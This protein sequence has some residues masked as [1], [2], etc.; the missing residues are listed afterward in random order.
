MSK[1]N[2]TSENLIDGNDFIAD[3]INNLLYYKL[4]VV[5]KTKEGKIFQVAL[6]QEM[7]DALY[8]ELKD[9]FKDGKV[10]I[11]PTEITTIDLD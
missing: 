7:C 1:E 3:V 11:L 2:E 9:F 8:G 5:I 10:K 4:A 6:D